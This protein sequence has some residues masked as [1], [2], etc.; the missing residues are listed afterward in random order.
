LYDGADDVDDE[1][2]DTTTQAAC[3]LIWAYMRVLG[4]QLFGQYLVQFL[5][6]V[7]DY[8]KTSRPPADRAMAIGC[9]GEI[10]QE[11]I[12]S[13]LGVSIMEQNWSSVFFQCIL[14]TI[15]DSENDNVQRN[16]AFCAGVSVEA[17]KD[18]ISIQDCQTL[19]QGLGPL[20]NRNANAGHAKD[21]PASDSAMACVD[22]AVAAVAR[23]IMHGPAGAIPLGQVLPVMLAALPLETD[24]TENDT[25]YNCVLGLLSMVHSNTDVQ[26][27]A[28]NIQRILTTVCQ[29]EGDGGVEEDMQQ[30]IKAALQSLNTR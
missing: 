25:V 1:D 14:A 17:L 24:F 7:V 18:R 26:A 22:N 28:A 8:C 2:H 19:L 30:K 15:G 9:L 11:C 16:A 21:T 20:L 29:D 27:N 12:D 6:H 10:A 23:M 13:E 4:P 5:P 3:D